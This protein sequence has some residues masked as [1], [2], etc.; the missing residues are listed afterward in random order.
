MKTVLFIRHASSS[1]DAFGYGDFERPLNEKGRREVLEM[2]EYLLQRE[3]VPGL[4]IS[5]PAKRACKTVELLLGHLGLPS[6]LMRKDMTL[7][8]PGPDSI[9]KAVEAVSDQIDNIAVCSHNPALTQLANEMVGNVTIDNMPPCSIF[10]I[11]TPIE[12]WLDFQKG[13]REFWFFKT[14]GGF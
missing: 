5:S 8:L 12:K 11:R 9:L 13:P 4:Y 14:P 6:H 3:S 10:G 7:Y 1:P 2:A